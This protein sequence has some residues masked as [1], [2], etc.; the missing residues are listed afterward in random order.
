M[1]ASVNYRFSQHLDAPPRDAYQWCI[2]Y[3]PDDLSLMHEKGQRRI[4]W[5]TEDTVILREVVHQNG[6]KIEKVKL[7]KLDRTRLSWYNIQLSGPNKHSAFLYRI[8]PEG[9]NQSRLNFT[10]LLV[11]YSKTR[12]SKRKL[13]QI[14]RKE[15]HY[16]SNAWKHLAKAM[17]ATRTTHSQ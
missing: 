13:R 8:S 16:D 10:G 11:V 12:L 3:Q 6:R 14:A 7:V 5:I 4:Q 17:L 2:D 15:K 1:Q 9:R